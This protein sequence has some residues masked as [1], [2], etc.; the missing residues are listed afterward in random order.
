MTELLRSTELSPAHEPFS[1]GVP[2][3]SLQ[4]PAPLVHHPQPR[5][6]PE[7]W[8]AAERT[9]AIGLAAAG[10]AG[11]SSTVKQVPW[12]GALVTAMAPLVTAQ[13][14]VNRSKSEAAS[15][16]LRGEEG[17]LRYGWMTRHFG[18]D[19]C[20]VHSPIT[21]EKRGSRKLDHSGRVWRGHFP[22][23]LLSRNLT[24]AHPN[25]VRK[26]YGVRGELCSRTHNQVHA[27]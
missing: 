2:A 14:S 19:T 12:P 11:G 16:E 17:A 15:N 13:N 27:D 22:E 6:V 10:A 9:E 25:W 26:H 24:W 18:N 3:P 23:S 4:R 21:A 5:R 7:P 1:R 20:D 8:I